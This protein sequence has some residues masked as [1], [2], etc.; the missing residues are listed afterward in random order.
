MFEKISSISQKK[1][2]KKYVYVDIC[3]DRFWGDYYHDLALCVNRN[4]QR[5]VSRLRMWGG[6]GL[7]ESTCPKKGGCRRARKVAVGNVEFPWRSDK[8][9]V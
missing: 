4:T 2:I 7:Q 3:I 5:T 8:V 1:E 6:C 9:S